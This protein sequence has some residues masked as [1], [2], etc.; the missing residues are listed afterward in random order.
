MEKFERI[1]VDHYV[2]VT[3]NQSVCDVVNAMLHKQAEKLFLITGFS[4]CGKTHFC[5][6]LFRCIDIQANPY[7]GKSNI[8]PMIFTGETLALALQED[9]KKSR[10]ERSVLPGSKLVIR[11]LLEIQEKQMGEGVV[12][13]IDDIDKF[14]FHQRELFLR[15][16]KLVSRHSIVATSRTLKELLPEVFSDFATVNLEDISV[17]SLKL[18]IYDFIEQYRVKRVTLLMVETLVYLYEVKKLGIGDIKEVLWEWKTCIDADATRHINQRSFHRYF[19]KYDLNHE[20]YQ[21]IK[22]ALIKDEMKFNI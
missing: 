10:G 11:N 9:V 1:V 5:N 22:D 7:V 15:L 6:E 21:F 20:A 16:R 2:K 13:I 19:Q 14:P 3:E 12:L 17:E 4:Q 18:I 8:K